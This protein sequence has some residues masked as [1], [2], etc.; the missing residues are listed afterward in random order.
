[1]GHAHF[2]RHPRPDDEVVELLE[3]LL[4]SARNGYVRSIVLAAV[5]PVNKVETACTGDLGDVRKTALLGGLLKVAI[6]LM[7]RP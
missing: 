5:N 4:S 7:K 1:M 3:K 6:A 2:R